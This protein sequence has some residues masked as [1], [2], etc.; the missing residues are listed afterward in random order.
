MLFQ[1]LEINCRQILLKNASIGVAGVSIGEKS[2]ADTR[3]PSVKQPAVK[4]P[5]LG[6]IA[7]NQ[8]LIQCPDQIYPVG[9]LAAL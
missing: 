2:S 8:R 1:L 9:A 6:Q 5:G 3:L 7:D 4:Q